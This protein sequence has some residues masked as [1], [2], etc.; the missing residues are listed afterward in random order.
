MLAEHLSDYAGRRDVVV[1]GL[2]RGGVPVAAQIAARLSAPLDVL[3]VRKLGLPGHPELAMGAIAGVGSAVEVVRNERVLAHERVPDEVFDAAYRRE[4]ATLRE[5]EGAFRRGRA[6]AAV[7][8]Q[9][10]IVVDDGLATGSTM[11]AALAAV[12]RQRPARLVVAVPVGS[13]ATCDGLAAEADEVVCAW[14][15]DGFSAVGQAYVDFSQTD[16]EQV[17]RAL[18]EVALAAAEHPTVST[19]PITTRRRAAM[20]VPPNDP[21]HPVPPGPDPSPGPVPSPVPGSPDPTDPPIPGPGPDPF[22]P[23]PTQPAPMPPHA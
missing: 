2:P 5:R 6:P 14:V 21:Q 11:R 4:L 18:G 20:T 3:V 15:P 10:V 23:D 12:R 16:D 22:P 17:H 19:C 13:A 8:D 7:H 9:V 1:L